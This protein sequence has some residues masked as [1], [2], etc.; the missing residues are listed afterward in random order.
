MGKV[1]VGKAEKP[2]KP[3]K[4]P[5]KQAIMPKT[6][7]CLPSK[8]TTKNGKYFIP[9]PSCVAEDLKTKQFKELA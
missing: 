5:K 2:S 9:K 7:V 4:P 1:Y 6:I 8:V 3:A